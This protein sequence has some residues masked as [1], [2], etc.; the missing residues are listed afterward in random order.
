MKLRSTY[1]QQSDE[2]HD[3]DDGD[4]QQVDAVLAVVVARVEGRSEAAA[5]ASQVAAAA[6]ARRAVIT[7]CSHRQ[8]R[9]RSRCHARRLHVQIARTDTHRAPR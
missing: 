3:G 9:L 1:D 2:S 4:A 5:A 6:V 8:R 7:D